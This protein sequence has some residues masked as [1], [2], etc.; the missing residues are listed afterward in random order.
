M[1]RVLLIS[2]DVATGSTSTWCC[3][4][5]KAALLLASCCVPVAPSIAQVIPPTTPVP[6]YPL[7]TKLTTL[8]V[9]DYWIYEQSGTM[10]V[11]ASGSTAAATLP[12]SGTFVEDV[13]T[14]TFQ[15]Q[16]TLALVVKQNLTIGGVS[17]YGNN[18]APEE[19]F[20]VEQ[21]PKTNDVLVLGDNATPTGTAEVAATPAEFY[22]GGWSMGASYNDALVFPSGKTGLYL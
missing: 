15:G 11:P 1:M 21:D 16:P 4:R 3:R 13:E 9:G 17:I 7:A 5:L 8:K 19:I 6:T 14:R 10:T 2:R 20:Y 12:L 22:L 18:P